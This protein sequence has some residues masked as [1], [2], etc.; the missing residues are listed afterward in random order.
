[1]ERTII[2]RRD[3]L[4]YVKKYRRYEKR[5]RNIPALSIPLSKTVRFNVIDHESQK[6][7]GLSNIRK[8]FRMF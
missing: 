4:R 5:H 2:V 1:M 7:K 8:Q 3:Y 6:S